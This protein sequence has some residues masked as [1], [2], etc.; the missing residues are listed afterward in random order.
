MYSDGDDHHEVKTMSINTQ[1]IRHRHM[2]KRVAGFV[3]GLGFPQ[4]SVI[5]LESWVIR[6]EKFEMIEYCI[7]A[8]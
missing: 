3:Q 6:R 7:Q 4:V 5:T 1:S 8:R 2:R